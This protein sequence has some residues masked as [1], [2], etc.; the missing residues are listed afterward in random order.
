MAKLGE[1]SQGAAVTK[2]VDEFFLRWP[3]S[4][5]HASLIPNMPHFGWSKFLLAEKMTSK[6]EITLFWGFVHPPDFS[7]QAGTLSTTTN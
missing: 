6:V 3:K 1:G 4:L 2:C 7:S 5:V